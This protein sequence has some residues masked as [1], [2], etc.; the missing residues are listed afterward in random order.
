V[1]LAAM[2][3]VV[4]TAQIPARLA[5]ILIDE[6]IESEPAL[7]FCFDALSSRDSESDALEHAIA[8]ALAMMMG[9]AA[10]LDSQCSCVRDRAVV[11]MEIRIG[12]GIARSFILAIGIRIELRAIAGFRDYLLRRCGSGERSSEQDRARQRMPGHGSS[13][14]PGVILITP[15]PAVYCETTADRAQNTISLDL[16]L[17]V[18]QGK[19]PSRLLRRCQAATIC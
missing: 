9:R 4:A 16:M 15:P 6:A 13:S 2:N 10:R 8:K 19:G 1:Q 18:R 14:S 11:S 17:P 7:I 3:L 5:P 12:I